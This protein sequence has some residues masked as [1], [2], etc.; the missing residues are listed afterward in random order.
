MAI[1]A[2]WVNSPTPGPTNVAPTS[3]GRSSSTTNF[4]P[5]LKPSKALAQQ[6][7][8]RDPPTHL[9]DANVQASTAGRPLRQPHAPH[10]RVC[11]HD[12]GHGVI[13]RPGRRLLAEDVV[14][15]LARLCWQKVGRMYKVE[16]YVR[17]RRA[18][19][20]D[21]TSTWEAAR[22]RSAPGYGAQ[23]AGLCNAAGLPAA[24]SSPKAEARALHRRHRPH[25]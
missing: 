16:L 11:E 10:L 5:P 13:V 7:R 19:M 14:S 6:R 15:R 9:H 23:D 12:G 4:T 3:T 1:V 25:H 8:G 18:C 22:V 21:G 24:D 2:A 17:V 20:V